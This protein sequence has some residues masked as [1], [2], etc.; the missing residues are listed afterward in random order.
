MIYSFDMDSG[1]LPTN[2]TVD[3]S[4]CNQLVFAVYDGY[5]VAMYSGKY[6]FAEIMLTKNMSNN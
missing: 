1:D 3:I 5:G 6:G 2:H 4:G